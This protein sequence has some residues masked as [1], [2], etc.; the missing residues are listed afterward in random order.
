MNTNFKNVTFV[1]ELI[2]K[3]QYTKNVKSNCLLLEEEFDYDGK[4]TTGK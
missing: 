4:Y 2:Y 1:T 3:R